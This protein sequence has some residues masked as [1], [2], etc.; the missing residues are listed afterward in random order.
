MWSVMR[1]MR[2]VR[3]ARSRPFEPWMTGGSSTHRG[4]KRLIITNC[5]IYMR[6]NC[7]QR[8]VSI[9]D[10]AGSYYPRAISSWFIMFLRN[11]C[12]PFGECGSVTR[13]EVGRNDVQCG[14]W[15]LWVRFLRVSSY[16]GHRCILGQWVTCCTVCYLQITRHLRAENLKRTTHP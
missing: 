1:R 2:V 12:S 7:I 4:P 10:T 11:L 5:C 15:F 9:E 13:M 16:L 8:E 14:I 3:T 6:Q